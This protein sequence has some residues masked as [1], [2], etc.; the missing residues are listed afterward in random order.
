MD[1]ATY[2]EEF[3]NLCLISRVQ[4]DEAI[5]VARYLEGPKWSIQE[6]INLWIPTIVHKCFQLSLKVEEKN[7]KKVD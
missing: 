3:Q 1:I 6:E 2:I 4:E 7:K 5:K